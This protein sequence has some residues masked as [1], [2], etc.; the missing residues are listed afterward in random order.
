[1]LTMTWEFSSMFTVSLMLI[2]IPLTSIFDDL[3]V[4]TWWF[5]LF[6]GLTFLIIGLTG[7]F[8]TENNYKNAIFFSSISYLILGLFTTLIVTINCTEAN[9]FYIEYVAYFG[10]PVGIILNAIGIFAG[11]KIRHN[12]F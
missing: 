11:F 6:P 8:I 2:F 4:Q 7:G 12:L 9:C 1:M 5:S 10:I 3:L